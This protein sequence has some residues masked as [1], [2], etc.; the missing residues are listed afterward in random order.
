MASELLPFLHQ[1][2]STLQT[3]ILRILVWIR[4]HNLMNA[5][6]Q[7]EMVISNAALHQRHPEPKA[8]QCSGLGIG[9]CRRA[10][11][12]TESS[13]TAS[14]QYPRVDWPEHPG[15]FF[16][17]LMGRA[18]LGFLLSHLPVGLQL[19]MY[20]SYQRHCNSGCFH[21]WTG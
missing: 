15:V 3:L 13:P 1:Y 11:F 2:S 5:D 16:G 10:R 7:T 14:S 18:T 20:Y 21:C 19:Y 8:C 17:V 9:Y 4:Y 6:R 12:R